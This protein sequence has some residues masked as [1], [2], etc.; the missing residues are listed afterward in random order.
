MVLRMV[1]NCE[2]PKDAKPA[3]NKN[4]CEYLE[5]LK[6]KTSLVLGARLLP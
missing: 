1:L 4:T 2:Y 5:A 3:A 6:L